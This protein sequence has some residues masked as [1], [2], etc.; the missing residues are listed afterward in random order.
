[1][2]STSLAGTCLPSL[3]VGDVT[4][5]SHSSSNLCAVYYPIANEITRV[6][7]LWG[8]TVVEVLSYAH[9]LDLTSGPGLIIVGNS[10]V[11]GPDCRPSTRQ[12]LPIRISRRGPER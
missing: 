6:P 8:G 3:P 5:S 12:R 2:R 10:G 7:S 9:G 4:E 1:M 11:R